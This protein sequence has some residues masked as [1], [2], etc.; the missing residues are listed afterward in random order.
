[1]FAEGHLLGLDHHNGVVYHN[2]NGIQLD[3]EIFGQGVLD[4]GEGHNLV[5]F[6]SSFRH[7]FLAH[8]VPADT[9][10]RCTQQ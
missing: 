8:H 1:M 5:G 7:P 9:T 6:L 2:F 4:S 3:I 10:A